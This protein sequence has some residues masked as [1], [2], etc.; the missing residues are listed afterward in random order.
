MP[1]IL[2]AEGSLAEAHFP[3]EMAL[4][5]HDDFDGI[6]RVQAQAFPK[7]NLIVLDLVRR[8][9]LDIEV[10]DQQFLE[11]RPDRGQLPIAFFS[12]APLRLNRV[13]GAMAP[14]SA[15]RVMTAAPAE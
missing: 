8:H 1:A 9:T 13:L 6:Q 14:S 15:M 7:K 2:A 11:F 12:R 5:N 3:P 4:Q 10:A